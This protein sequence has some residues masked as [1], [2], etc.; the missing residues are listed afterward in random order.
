MDPSEIKW[1]YQIL[2]SRNLIERFGDSFP[3][4]VLVTKG[5][6]GAQELET[7]AVDQVSLIISQ[8]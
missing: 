2:A 5:Y 1:S 3:I 8:T 4:F 7:L 6:Y